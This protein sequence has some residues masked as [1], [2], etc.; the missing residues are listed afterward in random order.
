[1]SDGRERVLLALSSPGLLAEVTTLLQG[2]PWDVRVARTAAEAR[3]IAPSLK[4][5]AVLLESR[6]ED[7]PGEALLRDLPRQEYVAVAVTTRRD[8]PEIAELFRAGAQDVL[9]WPE[10][11]QAEPR[12]SLEAALRVL[13]QRLEHTQKQLLL[14]R[15]VDWSYWK[16]LF[17]SQG[18]KSDRH[19]GVID[20]LNT[21]LNQ[22]GGLTMVLDMMRNCEVDA[23]GRRLLRQDLF[24]LVL[25]CLEP[26]AAF[27][28]GIADAN[29]L[30]AGDAALQDK[31]VEDL[32]A[33]LQ[34]W[35]DE[36]GWRLA[37]RRQRLKSSFGNLQESAGAW[38]V[39]LDAHRLRQAL[40]EALINAM[41]YSAEG[42]TLHFWAN[43]DD[44]RLE[45]VVLNPAYPTTQLYDGTRAVGV[46][47]HLESLVFEFFVK[48]HREVYE[49]FREPWPAGM[50]LTIVRRI[51]EGMNGA[52]TL[53]N[54]EMQADDTAGTS[55]EFRATLP[56]KAAA[57]CSFGVAKPEQ[58]E[59][60]AGVEL[61]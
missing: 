10:R 27:M 2:A 37:L 17:L 41:K 28:D 58:A 51:F 33:L 40:Q 38:G 20:H 46:P 21:Y 61:F 48:F 36:E 12:A 35:L 3:R 8:A 60:P 9:F 42:D 59:L 13:G 7:G 18:G 47:R 57:A 43:C 30:L 19:Q 23:E 15:Q 34:G 49:Q 32:P 55:V 24:E 11:A 6:L 50:G 44:G 52:C 25:T 5:C 4:P 54:V 1:M 56:L 14:R 53:R 22:S 26:V 29:R 45:L 31:R 16:G 39:A